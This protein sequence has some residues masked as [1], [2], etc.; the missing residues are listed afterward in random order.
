V[1]GSG[2]GAYRALLMEIGLPLLENIAGLRSALDSLGHE[3]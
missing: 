2:A 1:G 3:G